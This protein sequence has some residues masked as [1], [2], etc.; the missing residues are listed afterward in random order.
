MALTTARVQSILAL[1]ND[2]D[3]T[4][5]MGLL[6]LDVQDFVETG[7]GGDAPSVNVNEQAIAEQIAGSYADENEFVQALAEISTDVSGFVENFF[8]SAGGAVEDSDS[9]ARQVRSGETTLEDLRGSREAFNPGDDD[10]LGGA[11]PDNLVTI[12]SGAE[13]EWY[14]DESA[15]LWYVQYGLPR[16]NSG[17]VFEATTQ[18]MDAIF[19]VGFRPV[20]TSVRSLNDITKAD[21]VVFG[22]DIVEMSGEGNFEE[23]V[24]RVIAIAMDEGVLPDWASTDPEIMDLVYIAQVEDKS[25][26]W[27]VDQIAKTDSFAQRFPGIQSLVDLGLTTEESID[28]FLDFE[29]GVKGLA[30]RVGLDPTTVTPDTVGQLIGAGQS[31]DDVEFVF[32]IFDTMRSNSGAMRAFNEVLSARNL[33]PLSPDQQFEFL[34]GRAPQ[35]LYTLWEE[36]SFLDAARVSGLSELIGV[37]DAISLANRTEGITAREAAQAGMAEAAKLLL[38]FRSEIAADKFGINQD[39]LIDLSLGVAPRSGVSAAELQENMSRAVQSAQGALKSKTQ[40][41]FQFGPD[42]TPQAVSLSRLR[43]QT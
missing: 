27:L 1:F 3:L 33:A 11:D 14:F 7:D 36:S 15:G 39:D 38:R 37:Q 25:D 29:T 19:G 23:S 2:V 34:A 35:E 40:P 18:Q 22:G 30:Q 13:M 17:I 20:A 12:M 6:G 42:G 5:V 10:A 43:T 9:I 16:S 28:A 8:E 21:G 31:M 4:E 41:F 24:D 32:G 26:A